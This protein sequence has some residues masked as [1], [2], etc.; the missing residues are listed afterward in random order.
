VVF[1]SGTSGRPRAAILS[2]RALVAAAR[3]SEANLGWRDDDR[4][5]LCMPL[6]HVGGLSIVLR[7]LLA[8]RAL[9]LAP[10]GR[11]APREMAE[12]VARDRVTLVSLVPTML[13][14]LLEME[15]PWR[16][17]DHL[18]AVLLGGA[19]ADRRLLARAADR[20]VPVL[21]TYGLTEACSQV[22]TQPL[23]T[24]N[25]GE[26]GSGRPVRGV[27]LR[28][29][30]EDGDS[31]APSGRSGTVEVRGATLFS[32]YL[33]SDSAPSSRSWDPF[34]ADGWLRTGDVGRLD[35]DGFLHVL[36]RR[37]E[38]ITSGGEKVHPQAVEE[39]LESHPGVARACV[40]AVDDEEWGQVV[41]ATLVATDAGPPTGA[42][43]RDF[44]FRR[45]PPH[46][47]PRLFC[48]VDSL[49][50]TASGKLDR[51]AVHSAHAAR[52]GPLTGAGDEPGGGGGRRPSS[53]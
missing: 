38:M 16:P 2:R 26:L 24:S 23:G 22:T 37:D 10:E 50:L 41:A 46:E 45:L 39:A 20:G 19:P 12:Q 14:R 1:T 31:D 13:W 7:C 5:L 27:E 32:G 30:G 15:P 40:F 21:T 3:A 49:A 44:V 43:L 29:V 18:R 11:F 6:A 48:W 36:G 51:R 33:G 8:R 35:E 52:L 42:E 34:T 9:V 25:R 17:P 28:L 4:W 47:R 53:R